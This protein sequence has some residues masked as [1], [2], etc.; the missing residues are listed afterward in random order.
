V[1][2]LVE[3][4]LVPVQEDEMWL[5]VEPFPQTYK[6]QETV[7]PLYDLLHND[8]ESGQDVFHYHVNNR[9]VKGF[10]DRL[11]V[12]MPLKENQSL[13]YRFIK[14]VKDVETATTATELV[15]TSK[16]KHK[17]IVNGKCP[18]KGYDLTNEL[19]DENGVVTCPLHGLKFN[20]QKQL[21]K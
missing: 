6:R 9:Y 16:L 18:H 10:P 1:L 11:R 8:K 5:D 7:V 3:Y 14:K 12:D 15:N 20:K 2:C 17:C 13:Q 4:K 21:I 19:P